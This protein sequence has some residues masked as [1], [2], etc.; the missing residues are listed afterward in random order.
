MLFAFP[1]LI[2]SVSEIFQRL[3]I[4]YCHHHSDR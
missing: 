4:T 2:L 3:D 1:K